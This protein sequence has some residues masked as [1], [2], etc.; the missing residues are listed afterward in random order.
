MNA[1]GIG[2]LQGLKRTLRVLLTINV[3]AYTA[4]KKALRI[5][6]L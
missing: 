5:L 2:F 3:V 4:M 6:E 1:Y